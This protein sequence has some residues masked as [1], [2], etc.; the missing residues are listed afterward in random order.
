MLAPLLDDLAGEFRQRSGKTD[1]AAQSGLTQQ[2]DGRVVRRT[3]SPAGDR[4]PR[5]IDVPPSVGPSTTG[6]GSGCHSRPLRATVKGR[7]P[8]F[9]QTVPAASGSLAR[10][11][12]VCA[13]PQASHS[14]CTGTGNDHG[15][16][17]HG[18]CAGYRRPP[19]HDRGESGA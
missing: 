4:P 5:G 10:S 8:Q 13:S 11:G 19:E 1:T 7:A 3:D 12:I 6:Y 9:G 14:M 17:T 15:Q 18:C 2:D 16:L